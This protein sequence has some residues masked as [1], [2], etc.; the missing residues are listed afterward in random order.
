MNSYKVQKTSYNARYHPQQNP[1]ERVNRTIISAISAYLHNNHRLW[2]VHLPKIAQAIRLATHE[3]TGR[4]PAFLTF[5]RL[6]PT[7][8]NFYG[9]ISH[10]QKHIP[11]VA[12]TED[13]EKEL[14]KLEECYPTIRENLRLANQ[15]AANR[16]NL[17]CREVSFQPG[18]RVWKRNKVLSSAVDYF[19]AKL[20]PKF[21]PC[22]V[23]RR[24]GNLVYQLENLEGNDIG[25]WHVEDLKPDLT[26]LMNPN[27]Q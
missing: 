14:T 6:V 23:T 20:S 8:G 2:D 24:V 26:D 21:V 17:R 9:P 18:D 11:N 7:A 25:K 19:S 13:Y 27:V 5:G 16:Y 10:D 22:V 12:R 15:R 4:S 1:A 3:T